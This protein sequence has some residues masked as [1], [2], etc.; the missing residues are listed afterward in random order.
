[1]SYLV[2]SEMQ[3]LIDQAQEV[4]KKTL[5]VYTRMIGNPRNLEE[6]FHNFQGAVEKNNNEQ[7]IYFKIIEKLR[8]KQ[9]FPFVMETIRNSKNPMQVQT[10]FKS[11]VALPED[12]E[13]VRENI[14]TIIEIMKNNIETEAIYHGACLLYRI[15]TKYPEL[16]EKLQESN[17]IL[18]Y[19]DLQRL[20]KKFDVL[21][22]WETEGHRGKSK[23]G[24][25][26]NQEMF[27]DFALTFIK[28]Q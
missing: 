9:L 15:V 21:D 23:P 1:M 10:A 11:T 20:L 16:E 7:M 22:K 4:D 5:Q 24:Y 2:V 14:T 19:Q 26:K 28:F 27:M 6:F 3:N 8:N 18:T 13:V 25:F 17:L 12:I